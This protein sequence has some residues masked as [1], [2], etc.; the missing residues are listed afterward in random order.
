MYS[1]PSNLLE[2]GQTVRYCGHG[3][4]TLLSVWSLVSPGRSKSEGYDPGLVF[5][6]DQCVIKKNIWLKIAT[7]LG[8]S[9]KVLSC[10]FPAMFLSLII[11]IHK[12]LFSNIKVLNKCCSELQMLSTSITLCIWYIKI[13]IASRWRQLEVVR[14][15]ASFIPQHIAKFHRH[16]LTLICMRK[17]N[18]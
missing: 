6:W 4:P 3:N 8:K 1:W 15:I 18:P 5:W 7:E 14:Q 13:I 17:K 11:C 2:A 12:F 9:S 16:L 10:F